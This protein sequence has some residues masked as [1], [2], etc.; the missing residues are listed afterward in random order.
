MPRSVA[1]IGASC[2]V[3][4]WLMASVILPPVASLQSNAPA[5]QPSAPAADEPTAPAPYTERLRLKLREAPR[6]PT[7]RRNPFTFEQPRPEVEPRRGESPDALSPPVDVRAPLFELAGVATTEAPDGASRTAVLSTQGD[8][9]LARV[10]DVLSDG[11]RVVSIDDSAVTL[12]VA[13]Q[14]LVLRLKH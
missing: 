14:L 5:P 4:G 13:G 9:V 2:L 8:V 1:L 6:A 10:G 12:D 11:S 3:A 7:F